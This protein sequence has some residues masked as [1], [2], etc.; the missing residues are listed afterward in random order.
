MTPREET[1]NASTRH[2]HQFIDLP[3]V[4]DSRGSLTYVEESDHLPLDIS[5][6]YYLYDFSGEPRGKHAHRELKQ[7]MIALNGGLDI[8]L[9]NGENT[10]SLRLDDPSKGL[11]VPPGLWR[12]LDG[13]ETGT[14]CLVLASDSYDE[15][16]YIR[17][18]DEF[19]QWKAER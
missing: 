17:D 19:E 14:V 4:V 10:V 16:D 3:R 15:D 2:R 8:T 13:V 9:D 18:Y 1:D 7:V 6:V 11:Y 12:E 5:R